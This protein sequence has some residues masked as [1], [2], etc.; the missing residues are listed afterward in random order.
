MKKSLLLVSSVFTLVLT[1]CGANDPSLIV[2]NANDDVSST[3]YTITNAD[4]NYS[5]LKGLKDTALP[6]E[7]LSF[8]VRL[9]QGY[10]FNDKLTIYA[11]EAEV[12]FTESL[13]VYSFTM[14]SSDVVIDLDLGETEYSITLKSNFVKEVYLDDGETEL[15]KVEFSKPGVA[16]KFKAE[17][18]IDYEFT[19]MKVNG[20]T[21]LAGD[22]GF[23]HFVMPY[24]PVL[25]SSDDAAKAY[26]LTLDSTSLSA[27]SVVVYKN[28]STKDSINSAIKGETIYVEFTDNEGVLKSEHIIN[29]KDSDGGSL[30]TTQLEN[31]SIYTF[32]MISDNISI[33]VQ[34]KD[35]SAYVGHKLINKAWK[36][37]NL[38][39]SSGNE[40]SSKKYSN[41]SSN[42]TFNEDGSL[43]RMYIS[44]NWEPVS[45][46]YATYKAGSSTYGIYFT[47]HLICTP[48]SSSYT[49]SYVGTYNSDYDIK[50]LIFDNKSKMIIWIEDEEGTILENIY[51]AGAG[52]VYTNVE[53][54]VSDEEGT[55]SDAKGSNIGLETSFSIYNGNTLLGNI[56][57]GALTIVSSL[58]VTAT[59]PDQVDSIKFYNTNGEEITSSENN[60]KVTAKVI[61]KEEYEGNY[62]ID[63]I[64][65]KN[66]DVNSELG[67][68][69]VDD[70]SYSF[71]MPAAN[72][73]V[74][75]LTLKDFTAYKDA[76]WLGTYYTYNYY[77]SSKDR[78]FSDVTF[79]TERT[80]NGAGE[81]IVGNSTYTISNATLDVTGSM[82]YSDGSATNTL[83]YSK[84]IMV[85]N[86]AISNK[87]M[88]DLH[89]GLR[90]DDLDTEK[91]NISNISHYKYNT[92]SDF[93]WAYSF[94]KSGELFG[95]M[96]CY[97]GTMYMDV[98]FE[99]D[100]SSTV[101]TIGSGSTYTV[102]D[103][104]GIEIFHVA[105]NESGADIATPVNTEAE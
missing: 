91:A 22:D 14:P 65:I 69:K 35:L 103:K 13:G 46:N 43:K 79:F 88:Y 1:S 28:A 99:V 33:T 16:L 68:T 3:S 70:L 32:T 49:D 105:P 51:V 12:S 40:K 73:A 48:Y 90:L 89:I 45:D 92:T 58:S 5:Y 101:S 62:G 29:V 52:S 57:N 11:G 41:L 26:T 15:T 24:R 84:G 34:D 98:T 50:Y 31:T 85:I 71:T 47:E 23:Y 7:E 9:K 17:E 82:S 63:K 75:E 87:Y 67:K 104:E 60:V 86:Y 83:Y 61:L 76:P 55:L 81:F 39:T 4:K 21:I 77:S 56:K 10:Y 64:T 94:Y 72:V 37:W 96:F 8:E 25:I 78:Q 93:F 102:K 54:K 30:E 27:S 42:F 95:S 66:I 2:K 97:N 20:S 18:N 6:G 53:L 59:L 80:L 44:G 19:T 74:T 36:T 100:E 38:Y